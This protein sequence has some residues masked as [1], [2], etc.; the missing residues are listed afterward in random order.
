MVQEINATR[1]P[2]EERRSNTVY[3]YDTEIGKLETARG[4]EKRIEL[5]RKS[6]LEA[7]KDK[8]MSVSEIKKEMPKIRKA[9]M[10][11]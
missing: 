10:T 3:H 11:L 8:K 9:E 5:E 6:V 4:Y 2:P 1:V 7:L